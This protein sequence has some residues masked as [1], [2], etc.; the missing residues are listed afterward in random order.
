M[1]SGCT[2]RRDDREEQETQGGLR[3]YRTHRV[4]RGTGHTR[5]DR[6]HGREHRGYGDTKGVHRSTEKLTRGQ[7]NTLEGRGGHRRSLEVQGHT[8]G[9]KVQSTHRGHT[10]GHKGRTQDVLGTYRRTQKGT[11]VSSW[12]ASRK[13]DED[14]QSR[15]TEKPEDRQLVS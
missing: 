11:G 6:R 3:G 5:V 14:D 2:R 10:G 4:K 12:E 13:D 15:R 8:Q 9:K 7:R 1:T